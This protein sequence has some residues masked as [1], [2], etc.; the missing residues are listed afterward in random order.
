MSSHLSMQ[1]AFL[2]YGSSRVHYAFAGSG[3]QLLFCFHGYG[4]SGASFSPLCQGAGLR[5]V[6]TLIAIDLP[7]HGKTSW[8]EELLLT[9][10][11]L[12]DIMT[13][14]TE[15]LHLTGSEVSLLGFSMG[16][17]IAL[18]LPALMPR[19]PKLIVA[20]AP[21]GL[22]MSF[23][24]WISTQTSW[25][26]RFFGYTM[27][28]PGWLTLAMQAGQRMGLVNKS[29][30]R[31]ASHYM[32]EPAV[33]QDLYHRWTTLRKF[34]PRLST[35]QAVILQTR[36]RVVLIYGEHD[37]IIRHERAEKFQKGVAQYCD[38][39]VVPGGH[40]HLL[41]SNC[42]LLIQILLSPYT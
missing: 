36:I 6:Y 16:G 37:R 41:R 4:E 13:R 20:L 2:D 26:N 5:A 11:G 10:E 3:K 22:R 27:K 12:L 28:H 21:D 39:R 38:I 7:F 30:F 18:S 34:R 25:G 17:R 40:Q 15:H 1:S 8:K 35:L 29:I 33:R 23:W 31:F 14:I 19:K 42:S 9:P 32:H 24:Y